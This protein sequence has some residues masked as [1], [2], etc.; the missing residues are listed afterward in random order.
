MQIAERDTDSGNQHKSKKGVVTLII[1]SFNTAEFLKPIEKAF[2]HISVFVDLLIKWPG[3]QH[4][5]S[6][7]MK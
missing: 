2:Y 3:Q 6:G 4:L 5:K 7:I 1:A